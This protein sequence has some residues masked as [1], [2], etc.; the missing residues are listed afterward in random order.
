MR[1]RAMSVAYI[2]GTS[3]ERHDRYTVAEL[4]AA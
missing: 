4:T 3:T 1:Q 2:G